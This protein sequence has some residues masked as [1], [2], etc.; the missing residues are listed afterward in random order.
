MKRDMNLIREILLE[1]ER[2]PT[3]EFYQLEIPGRQT[4]EVVHHLYLL[5]D[6]GFIEGQVVSGTD[7]PI[8]VQAMTWAGCEFLD[9]ARSETIWNATMK[10]I[11]ETTGAVAMPVLISLLTMEAKRVLGLAP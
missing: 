10:K 1:I 7:M 4:D 2:Y 8:I 5:M 11:G 9:A 3:R 6:A